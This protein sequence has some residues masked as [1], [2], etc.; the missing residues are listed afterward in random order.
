[1]DAMTDDTLPSIE[2][3]RFVTDDLT[4]AHADVSWRTG[5]WN[6]V[7]GAIVCC[8]HGLHASVT[9]RDSVRNVYGQRWFLAEARGEISHQGNKFAAS[10]MRL[11]EEIPS[12]VL[13]RFAVVCARRSFDYLEKRH[14]T[15]ARILQCI[16]ATDDFLDGTAGEHVLL[17]GREAAA[18]VIGSGAATGPDTGRAIAAAIAASRAANGD[19]ASWTAAAAGAAHAAHVAADAID[20]AATLT[21]AYASVHNVAAG[22]AT[23]NVAD[24]A[25]A[26][27][28]RAA[29]SG[30]VAHAAAVAAARGVYAADTA[31]D[32][33]F[34][35]FSAATSQSADSH[36]LA[37][38]ADLVELIANSRA[39]R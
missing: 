26:A 35:A 25:A 6:E 17:D 12:A 20:A 19:A 11:V 14:P 31:A 22:F 3:Y 2:C 38:N 27:A 21:A 4:S 16:Q 10:E 34:A 23:A 28:R 1:M 5:E 29:A 39:K 32:A 9:P 15:D 36:Y 7:G 37:Q 24:E 30:A 33:Y 13:R 8:S 18:A